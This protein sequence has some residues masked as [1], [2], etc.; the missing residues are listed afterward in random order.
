MHITS[1]KGEIAVLSVELEANKRGCI[2]SHPSNQHSRYDLI[3]DDGKRLLR[4]QVKYLNRKGNR[5]N[6]LELII[7]GGTKKIKRYTSKEIDL[8]LI[9]VP[10]K[11]CILCLRP[12]QFNNKNT[13]FFHME[14]K[15]T[16]SYY[17]NFLW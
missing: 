11:N 8:L 13:F 9:Y 10:Q 6:C 7:S 17:E 12:T 5:K 4:T 16:P 2:I 3:I 14:N 15:N 1:N